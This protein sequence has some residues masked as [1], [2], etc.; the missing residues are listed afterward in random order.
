MPA[1]IVAVHDDRCFL[2]CLTAALQ[3]QGH[4]VAAF[5]D[6]ILA[7]DALHAAQHVEVLITR[8]RFPS[9]TPHGIALAHWAQANRP[10]VRVLFTALPEL[11]P[12]AEGLGL[13][14]PMP[15]SVPK[16]VEIVARLLATDQSLW[17]YRPR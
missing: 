15:L 17:D 5:D 13:F 6:S 12:H 14:L 8:I 10:R 2:D 16:V 11:E 7:W 9:G 4:E 3:A 1:R